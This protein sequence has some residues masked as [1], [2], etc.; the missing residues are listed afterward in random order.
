MGSGRGP[1]RGS[2][3]ETLALVRRLPPTLAGWVQSRPVAAVPGMRRAFKRTWAEVRGSTL[4]LYAVAPYSTASTADE[5]AADTPPDAVALI[6]LKDCK[7][8]MDAA[9]FR[10]KTKH[11]VASDAGAG[12]LAIG[13]ELQ[14]ADRDMTLSWNGA[15]SAAGTTRAI[16]LSDFEVLKPIGRGAS[17]R[18]FLVREKNG[19]EDLALKVIE[20]ESVYEN[21][22][23]FRHALDERMVLELACDHPFILKMRHAFQTS[24]RLYIVTEFAKGGDL[25]DFLK[26]RGKPFTEQIVV[27]MAG[28]M[29]LALQHIHKLGVVYRDLKLENVLLDIDGHVRIADFGLS[30]MLGKPRKS[31]EPGTLDEG[32]GYGQDQDIGMTRTFCGT[33]EMIAP[34][35][36]SGAA[37]GL[38]VDV[39]A[40]GILVYETMAGR[41]PFYSKNRDEVYDRIESA[42]LR[43]PRHFSAEAVSLLRGLLDRNPKTRLG[44][45]PDGLEAVKRHPFF[46]TVNWEELYNMV[47]HEDNIDVIGTLGLPDRGQRVPIKK[48]GP[49]S[50]AAREIADVLSAEDEAGAARAGK[51]NLFSRFSAGKNKV[52]SIAGYSFTSVPKSSDVHLSQL[53]G[54]MASSPSSVATSSARTTPRSTLSSATPVSVGPTR[55]APPAAVKP[56][57]L[58][59]G[60]QAAKDARGAAVGVSTERPTEQLAADRPRPPPAPSSDVV[61]PPPM[62]RVKSTRAAAGVP[63][64]DDSRTEMDRVRGPDSLVRNSSNRPGALTTAALEAG[65]SGG[66]ERPPTPPPM[67]R[68]PSRR[69]PSP[70]G[71]A[72]TPRP[73]TPP[74]P[75]RAPPAAPPPLPPQ[76]SSPSVPAQRPTPAP[77]PARPPSAL[78]PLPPLPPK[79][80]DVGS[81]EVVSSGNDR[82]WRDVQQSQEDELRRQQ[83]LQRRRLEK[84]AELDGRHVPSSRPANEHRP[85]PVTDY[86]GSSSRTGQPS[87]GLPSSTSMH[88][89]QVA[90]DSHG[91]RSPG[92]ASSSSVRQLPSDGGR[93]GMPNIDEIRALAAQLARDQGTGRHGSQPYPPAG[94]SNKSQGGDDYGHSK[95]H[96]GGAEQATSSR[97]RA[98]PSD[99]IGRY[100]DSSRREPQPPPSQYSSGRGMDRIRSERVA[101][102][103]QGGGMS[104]E[105]HRSRGGLAR[106]TSVGPMPSSSRNSPY[107]GS[108]SS[109]GSSTRNSGRGSGGS[110]D[111]PDVTVNTVP[112]GNGL[113]RVTSVGPLPRQ[114]PTPNVLYG[115]SSSNKYQAVP[116]GSPAD[117]LKKSASSRAAPSTPSGSSQQRRAW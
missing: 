36:L 113:V 52:S 104:A 100:A 88:Q 87:G 27:R 53:S 50:A 81:L 61:E 2:H 30:K 3:E 95:G 41:T 89:P 109:G 11:P 108:S 72:N 44:M 86:Y 101:P 25:F 68:V 8:K 75:T 63:P 66:R 67:R 42:P 22:D 94:S 65:S 62:A 99:G 13:I 38:S 37:Y 14:L 70:G 5:V 19:E 64:Q 56:E 78:E 1:T 107:V 45:G 69:A 7:V 9:R 21:D 17:G 117:S 16:G 43:F 102:Q 60:L 32:G 47:P 114:M 92:L 90:G 57:S 35:A 115:R 4:L 15:I 106:V 116:F 33:R 73:G 97:S 23:A 77:A 84:R 24:K 82:K 103:R 46:R 39:W 112:A 59:D 80:D 58:R 34:E 76:P 71:A 85:T 6:G 31:T 98:S 110:N 28:E 54:P 12:S 96:Y 26:K 74:L 18:V 93:S 51:Q 83:E 91:R 29:L 55:P 79:P 111:R 48:P 10:L 105:E 40:F 20:K 49:N